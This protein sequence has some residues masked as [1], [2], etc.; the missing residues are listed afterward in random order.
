[1]DCPFYTFLKYGKFSR[2]L[3]LFMYLCLAVCECLRPGGQRE[4]VQVV[5]L[6]VVVGPGGGAA[7]EVGPAKELG[8]N[9]AGAAARGLAVGHL[10]VGKKVSFH[11]ILFGKVI[12]YGAESY[13]YTDIVTN[14]FATFDYL[15][16]FFIL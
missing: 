16:K 6:A 13:F 10:G 7:V 12:T 14:F 4:V 15:K 9:L 1:M 3:K 5:E 11:F 8:L 2:V